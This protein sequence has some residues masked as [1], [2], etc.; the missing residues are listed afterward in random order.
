MP[1]LEID[2]V[3]E[4]LVTLG[5]A[6]RGRR[7]SGYRVTATTVLTAAHVVRDASKVRVRFD[8]DQ[9]GEWSAD[10]TGVVEVP[11]VDVALLT[12]RAPDRADV[13][14]ALF[15]RIG[16]RDTLIECSAV[17][18]PLWKLRG[19]RAASYRD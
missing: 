1:G 11:E 18:F 5:A 13:V 8:A 7:G 14:P 4:I 9:P 12:I 17:G 16:E 3:A 10:A 19:D 6:E 15:G 2:R